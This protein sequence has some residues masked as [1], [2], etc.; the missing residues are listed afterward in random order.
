MISVPPAFEPL[1]S[2]HRYKVL[3]GGRGSGKSESVARYCL[4]KGM[5]KPRKIVCGREFQ[6][7]IKESVYDMLVSF[8]EMYNLR[9]FYTVLNTEIRGINGTTFSF[10]GLR[11]NIASIKSMYDVD[12][13]WGEEAQTF[14]A[15]SLTVLLPTIRAVDSELIFTMN[16]DLEED[17]S[18]QM[19]VAEPPP[20]TLVLTVNYMDNPYFPDNLR[21]LMEDQKGKDF[22]K[23]LNVWEGQCKQAVEGAI[24][25][26]QI[27]KATEEG[28]IN[29]EV[30]YNNS[31]PVHTYWD[32]GKA[33]KTAIWFAQYVGMQ[34][35]I[36][37]CIVGFGKDLE[38]Y[39]EEI[40]SLPYGYGTHYLPHDARQDRL[41]MQRSVE[42]QVRQALGNVEVVERVQHKINAIE[43]AKEIMGICHFHKSDCADGLYNMRRYAYKVRED[44]TVSQEPDHQFSDACFVAGTKVLTA[45]GEKNIEDIQKGE[46]VWTPCGY[47]EVLNAGSRRAAKQ[48]LKIQFT[49]G[50]SITCTPDHKVFTDRGLVRADALMYS[51]WVWNQKYHRQLPL[52]AKCTNYRE[53]ITKGMTTA[54]ASI[55]PFIE[56]YGL[57]IMAQS[58]EVTTST[59][60][61]ATALIIPSTIWN[62]SLPTSIY[63]N[64]RK[65]ATGFFQGSLNNAFLRKLFLL[66]KHGTQANRGMNGTLNTGKEHGRTDSGSQSSVET[67]RDNTELR[68]LHAPS[69]VP[70][71]VLTKQELSEEDGVLVYDLSV[72][73]HHC[74]LA[75][76]LLVSNCDAFMTFAMSAQPDRIEDDRPAYQSPSPRLG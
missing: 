57:T 53:A 20:D 45:T 23:Y 29:D 68:S 44:G 16:P 42:D 2:K 18:Y 24:F 8:I 40:E 36:L 64:M 37:R 34:W 28:R 56:Q 38:D 31:I 48:L 49:D 12:I 26:R 61:T 75:N 14:S 50:T 11:H 33:N 6:S 54:E 66:L 47:A 27:E 58:Q 76:G 63:Q 74:Y 55:A 71:I 43:A 22:E 15:N 1:F 7:S 52:M 39:L 25:A 35:R 69:I 32:L 19:L 5:E 41:G 51:D 46:R 13:F 62:A 60:K 4:A 59:T 65:R 21:A 17:P 10:V 67:V 73:G 9:S 70:S 3:K 72:K 30:E